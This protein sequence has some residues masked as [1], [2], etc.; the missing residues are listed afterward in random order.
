MA[1]FKKPYGIWLAILAIIPNTVSTYISVIES[2]A[3]SVAVLIGSESVQDPE[4]PSRNP[5][6]I[7]E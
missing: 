3:D 5:D 4:M 6:P 7:S 2:K 1:F